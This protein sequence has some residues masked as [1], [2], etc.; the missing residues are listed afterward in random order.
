MTDDFLMNFMALWAGN[1]ALTN[2]NS[3]RISNA[4]TWEI[5]AKIGSG[6]G[7]APNRQLALLEPMLTY[8]QL[9]P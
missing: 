6:K 2:I 3:L 4:M 8:C 1:N 7:L 9:D 5:F